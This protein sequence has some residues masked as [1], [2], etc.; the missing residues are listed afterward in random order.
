MAGLGLH[1]VLVAIPAGSEGALREFYEGVVGLAEIPKPPL[2]AARGGVWFRVGDGQELHCG[3]ESD[4][5]PARKAH[6]CL[7][8]D[9]LD[10]LAGRVAARG[11]E[12]TWAE[13]IPGVR[14][15]HTF[16]PVGNRIE[17]QGPR[18]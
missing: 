16:D 9:D 4:F 10:D 6:P 1:H 15:F 8:V 14:R 7:V 11:G 3:V 5:A 13:E 17:F 2:L 18:D 12:V